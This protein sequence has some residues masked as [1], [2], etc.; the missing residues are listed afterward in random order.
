MTTK[1]RQDPMGRFAVVYEPGL[2]RLP[3]LSGP[4]N[5]SADGGEQSVAC[6]FCP[7]NERYCQFSID[8][9]GEKK[10]WKLR[11]IPNR[12]PFFPL[13]VAKRLS[14]TVSMISMVVPVPMR[15]SS[16]VQN[17]GS[18]PLPLPRR[19]GATFLP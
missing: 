4:G 14:P 2:A 9:F 7:G 1:L 15:S 12:L 10:D 17:T 3:L 8:Q 5:G 18:R 11:V 19:S 16:K 13:K 6:P